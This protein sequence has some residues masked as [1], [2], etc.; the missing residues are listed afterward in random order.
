MANAKIKEDKSNIVP[1]LN[2]EL[3]AKS[4]LPDGGWGWVVCLSCW[5]GNFSGAGPVFAYGIIL[6]ALTE[7]Y[8]DGV[9]II[10]LVGSVLSALG[11]AVGPVAAMMTNMLGLRAVY[12]LGSFSFPGMKFFL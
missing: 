8:K 2:V 5:F 9:F 3:A 4:S 12:I 6:P 10:S 1:D 11:F 7:Y